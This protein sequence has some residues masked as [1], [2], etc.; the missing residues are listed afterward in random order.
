MLIRDGDEGDS[1]GVVIDFFDEIVGFFD[2]FVELVFRLFVGVYFVVSNNE[3]F[4]IEGEGEEGVFLGLIV[5]GDISFEFIDI[6][7]N[8]EDG[9]VS[10]GGI[11]DYVFDEVL[12]IGGV[13]DGNLVFRGFEFLKSN[14]D[15]DILFLFG[16]KFVKNLSVF[17]RSLKKG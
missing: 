2:D 13:N 8:D 5:F 15:G 10:L 12:V 4:N 9:I 11:G 14:V 6:G 17:E 1:F 3:L 7:G 16:F